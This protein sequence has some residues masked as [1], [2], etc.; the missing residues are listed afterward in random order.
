MTVAE[1][2]DALKKMPA[3]LEVMGCDLDNEHFYSFKSIKKTKLVKKTMLEF[4]ESCDDPN[5]ET[6][7]V[8]EMELL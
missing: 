3:D 7:M 1:L 6:V 5:L 4:D 8:V 2:I